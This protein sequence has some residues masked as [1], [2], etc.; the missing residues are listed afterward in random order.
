MVGS[1]ICTQR[2]GCVCK[3]PLL[4]MKARVLPGRPTQTHHCSRIIKTLQTASPTP[5]RPQEGP[6]PATAPGSAG[7]P[8]GTSPGCGG[9]TRLPSR[10]R[11]PQLSD[12]WASLRRPLESQR[13]LRTCLLHVGQI[14]LRDFVEK[15][16]VW[17]HLS[18][19]L[20]FPLL[21]GQLSSG[22][23][24]REFLRISVS[25]QSVS[26]RGGRGRQ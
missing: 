16:P 3:G 20:V 13:K 2:K 22:Q 14:R 4:S 17:L 26:E 11:L 18:S 7:V 19:T 12:G 5:K 6:A 9:K 23:Q 1:L 10:R 25:L 24:E 21:S 15:S 8:V